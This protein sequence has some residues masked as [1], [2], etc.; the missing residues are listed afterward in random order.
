MLVA[1]FRST[2]DTITSSKVTTPVAAP[3]C[4]IA[5]VAEPVAQNDEHAKSAQ[6]TK[7]LPSLSMVSEH[8]A[9]VSS[10]AQPV[11]PVPISDVMRGRIFQS[12]K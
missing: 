2:A 1:P 6:S 7:P 4:T 10:V 12:K 8:S 9:I 11:P 3:V 5:M